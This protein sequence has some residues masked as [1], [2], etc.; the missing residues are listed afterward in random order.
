MDQTTSAEHHGATPDR[1][2]D[3]HEL[4]GDLQ[5]QQNVCAISAA[6]ASTTTVDAPIVGAPHNVAPASNLEATPKPTPQLAPWSAPTGAQRMDAAAKLDTEAPATTPA[7]DASAAPPTPLPDGAWETVIQS[8]HTLPAQAR[9][10]PWLHHQRRGTLHG[11]RVVHRLRRH[12]RRHH[13]QDARS[14]PNRPP[15]GPDRPLRPHHRQRLR[16]AF[17]RALRRRHRQKEPPHPLGM[18]DLGRH[19]TRRACGTRP[20]GPPGPQARPPR[21]NGLRDQPRRAKRPEGLPCTPHRTDL[22]CCRIRRRRMSVGVW[23]R[24]HGRLMRPPV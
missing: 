16:R 2:N 20:P 10:R 18:R 7:T 17:R 11:G 24:H 19:L 12:P 8:P 15:V 22:F 13:A 5:L 14:H 23:R 21:R 1:K 3:A 6:A 4:S 9:A